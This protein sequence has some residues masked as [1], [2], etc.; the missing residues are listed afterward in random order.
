MASRHPRTYLGIHGIVGLALAVACAWAFAAIADEVPENGNLVR[1]DST[2][3]VWLQLHGTEKGESVF[4]AISH[5]GGELLVVA[6]GLTAA[7]LLLRRSWRR[8]SF[9]T[10]AC[11]G[12]GPLHVLLAGTFRRER[13]SFASEFVSN[14][15]F[16][17]PSGHAMESLVVYGVVAFL[18]AERFPQTRPITWV[19]WLAV[20]GVIGFSRLYLGVHYISDVV[21]GFAAGFVWLFTCITGYRFAE[22]RHLGSQ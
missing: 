2:A 3:A 14:G 17:F 1:A 19:A 15:S 16:S 21:A 10:V 4:A 6:A 9:V 5:L 11:A 8:L 7:V 12:I 20:A 22:R 18:I 13:P